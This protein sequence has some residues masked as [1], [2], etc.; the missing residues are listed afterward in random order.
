MKS[1][2]ELARV[3]SSGAGSRARADGQGMGFTMISPRF[4]LLM[5]STKMP[6]LDAP[7]NNRFT[8]VRPSPVGIADWLGLKKN[9]LKTFSPPSPIP[10]DIRTSI[11]QTSGEIA[12]NA[13]EIA[14]KLIEAGTSSRRSM[15]IGA[16]TAGW[17]WWTGDET[18]VVHQTPRSLDKSVDAYELIMEILGHRIRTAEGH[19]R[20]LLDLVLVEDTRQ[21]ARSYG[22]DFTPL[23]GLVIA[24]THQGIKRALARSRFKNADVNQLLLQLPQVTIPSNPRRIGGLRVRPLIVPPSICEKIGIDIYEER[25]D[26]NRTLPYE[27]P[28]GENPW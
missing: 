1:V 25:E 8:L 19:D 15:I 27:D 24:P 20:S 14:D 22:I 9:L 21:T 2:I 13:T 12:A 7:D 11:I 23:E 16:L 6:F 26:A 17:N 10:T 3:A 28:R 5:N 18:P 4:S